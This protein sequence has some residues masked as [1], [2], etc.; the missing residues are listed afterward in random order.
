[1]SFG[2]NL[3][4]SLFSIKLTGVIHFI[5]LYKNIVFVFV[6]FTTKN[7]KKFRIQKNIKERCEEI[8]PK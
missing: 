5:E 1:M 8:F 3:S 6:S 4:L 2:K 7:L